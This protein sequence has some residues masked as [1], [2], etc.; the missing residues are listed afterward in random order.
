M[1][2]VT[3]EIKI[4]EKHMGHCKKFLFKISTCELECKNKCEISRC[5][6]QLIDDEQIK[7]FHNFD[8][9][10]ICAIQDDT[11]IM[12]RFTYEQVYNFLVSTFTEI[13][14]DISITYYYKLLT[15]CEL[16][17]DKNR[18]VDKL[19]FEIRYNNKLFVDFDVNK[20]YYLNETVNIQLNDNNINFIFGD[21]KLIIE[22]PS[23]HKSVFVNS[24]IIT[25]SKPFNYDYYEFNKF[26]K[27]F[28]DN[29]IKSCVLK[30]ENSELIFDFTVSKSKIKFPLRKI[31]FITNYLSSFF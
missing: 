8:T 11:K 23:K 29:K 10:S 9:H 13:N 30:F 31:N 3:G 12:N 26:L 6:L 4:N 27:S 14:Y 21:E 22:I 2:P 20:Q 7:Y 25:I 28:K 5:E 16:Q 17:D 15:L 1:K 24:E 19:Y 18:D